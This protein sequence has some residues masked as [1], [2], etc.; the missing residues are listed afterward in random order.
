MTQVATMQRICVKVKNWTSNVAVCSH[1]PPCRLHR[2]TPTEHIGQSCCSLDTGEKKKDPAK[3]NQKAAPSS[4]LLKSWFWLRAYRQA[5]RLVV[6]GTLHS[7]WTPTCG[8]SSMS[9]WCWRCC[10]WCSATGPNSSGSGGSRALC[11]VPS[12]C[13]RFVRES[14]NWNWCLFV[15]FLTAA[16]Q[17]VLNATQREAAGEPRAD[18]ETPP[19]L[20]PAEKTQ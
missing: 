15:L 17:L 12:D 6:G 8:S 2:A 13:W 3:S 7:V 20:C 18:P 14:N 5:G 10:S 11:P 1:V 4:S 19:Q 9:W 16:I